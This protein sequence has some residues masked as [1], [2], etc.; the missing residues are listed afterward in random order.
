MG[1]QLKFGLPFALFGLPLACLAVTTEQGTAWFVAIAAYV[2]GSVLV[3]FEYMEIAYRTPATVIFTRLLLCF[4]LAL[5]AAVAY[6]AFVTGN[7]DQ[8]LEARRE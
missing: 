5:L 3:Q 8:L 2:L 6:A 1:F 7:V 4:G